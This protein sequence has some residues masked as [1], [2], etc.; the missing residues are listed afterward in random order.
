MTFD[1]LKAANKAIKTTDIKGKAYAEVNERI[2][3]FRMLY[4]NG[5]ISTEIVEI[6]QDEKGKGVV[7]FKATALN[8]QGAVLGV[9]HAY[10]KEGSSFINSTSYIENAETSA[11]GRALGMIGIG[12]DTSVASY[13]EVANAQA[14][15]ADTKKA[16]EPKK[17]AQPKKKA[18]DQVQP[19]PQAQPTAAETAP[20]APDNGLPFE[21][22][23]ET[24]RDKFRNYVNAH[25]MTKNQVVQ[26][27]TA[28]RLQ[29]SSPDSEW[30]NAL[31]YAISINGG[32]ET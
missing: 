12:I 1:E 29:D 11:V 15:Q 20:T 21:I 32:V 26:I 25:K 24:N 3:A 27:L 7:I 22:D 19:Q 13:E 14:Q 6:R 5:T 10:E 2:K 31:A 17:A 9:G 8:E 16:T 4:P 30:E 23:T 18:A 28:C